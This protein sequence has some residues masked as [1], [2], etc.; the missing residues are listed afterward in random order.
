MSSAAW[1]IA[2][3]V[4]GD[5]TIVPHTGGRCMGL[6]QYIARKPNATGIRLYVLAD[7]IG[8]GGYVVDVYL[9]TGRRGKVRRFGSCAE[10]SDAKRIVGLW[11]RLIPLGTVFVADSF[12]GSHKTSRPVG[13][14]T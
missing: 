4:C 7:N 12:S 8:G 2:G 1:D 6:R 3:A 11:S 5:E 13:P 10:K 14:L 9:Y